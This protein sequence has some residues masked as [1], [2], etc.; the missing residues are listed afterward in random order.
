[1]SWDLDLDEASYFLDLG[2]ASP[3]CGLRYA[4]ALVG[5][6]SWELTMDEQS[7]LKNG[8]S[9]SSCRK[10]KLKE[11]NKSFVSEPRESSV[12]R[13]YRIPVRMN[14]L[15]TFFTYPYITH[16][17]IYIYIYIYIYMYLCMHVHIY[18]YTGIYLYMYI[19]TCAYVYIH[20]HIY[21]YTTIY[22]CIYVYRSNS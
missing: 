5:S 17:Y 10:P 14:I 8:V 2:E 18:A 16:T 20:I 3:V 1:M 12:F 15:W 9:L 22:T 11:G 6:V 19:Q 21:T 4:C 13:V 7:A